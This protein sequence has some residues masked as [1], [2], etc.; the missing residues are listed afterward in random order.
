MTWVAGQKLRASDLN[1]AGPQF[2]RVLTDQTKNTSVA[3]GSVTGLSAELEANSAY[4]MDAMVL[5]TSSAVADLKLAIT[6]PTGVGGAWSAG[7]IALLAGASSGDLDLAYTTTITDVGIRSLTGGTG[8]FMCMPR[9]YFT[10]GA[11]AG[12][13]QFRFAQNTSEVSN[14]VI[15][16]GS[17]IRVQK[18]T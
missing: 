8:N 18:I 5:Y 4:A 3:F 10:T 15:K 16:V 11:T 9:G 12:T 14:T 6:G 13:L 17:W 1:E 7:G 2:G